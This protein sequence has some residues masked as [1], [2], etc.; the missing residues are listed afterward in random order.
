MGALE[1]AAAS[2]SLTMRLSAVS[3][4]TLV[5]RKRKLPEVFTVAPTTLSPTPSSTGMLS[6]VSMDW[7][8]APWPSRITPSVGTLCPSR[9]STSSPT[10]SSDASISVSTPSRITVARR[11]ARSSRREMASDVRPLARAS[12]VLPTE[13]SVTIIAA[14]SK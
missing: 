9:T 10:A 1:L 12:S 14:D 5:T 13:I 7:S 4:P 11:G 2:T 6:P 3:S 8:S